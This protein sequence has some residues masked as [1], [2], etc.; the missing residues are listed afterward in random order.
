MAYISSEQLE[1]ALPDGSTISDWSGGDDAKVEQAIETAQ[2]EV[3]G[4]L[5]SGGYAVPLDPPPENIKNY[6]IDIAVYNMA[7]VSGFRADSADNELKTKYEKALD[8]LKGVATGK[9]RIPISVGN[10][11]EDSRAVPRMGFKVRGGRKM[12]MDGYWDGRS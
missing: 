6:T 9:Y 4:Y 8:F 10:S 3:D 2:G 1:R 12:N 5:I 7:V 11:D